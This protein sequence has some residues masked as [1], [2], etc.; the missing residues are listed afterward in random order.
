MG[1][2]LW[3]IKASTA[4]AAVGFICLILAAILRCDT[5]VSIAC[6]FFFGWV[7]LMLYAVAYAMTERHLTAI[8]LCLAFLAALYFLIFF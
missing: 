5:L 2:G 8:P 6:I 7:I 3:P 4:S 1:K